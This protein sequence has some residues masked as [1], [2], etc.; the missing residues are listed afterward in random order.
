MVVLLVPGWLREK[1]GVESR[2]SQGRERRG[3]SRRYSR[4]KAA[5]KE[6][7]EGAKDGGVW[8][9][10]TWLSGSLRALAQRRSWKSCVNLSHRRKLG[11][12]QQPLPSRRSDPAAPLLSLP[13]D[14]PVWGFPFTGPELALVLPVR[15]S[16][17]EGAPHSCSGSVVQLG[18][19]CL[20]TPHG[21][22]CWGH[23]RVQELADLH[24]QK[25]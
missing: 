5:G 23:E 10:S 25:H 6:Q 18:A 22:A 3:H 2:E 15:F 20:P 16:P 13:W 8:R 9:W 4:A 7:G 14:H 19:S 21:K 1:S 12:F 24:S 11:L 17:Q